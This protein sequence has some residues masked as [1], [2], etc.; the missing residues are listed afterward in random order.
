M[1][2]E[3]RLNVRLALSSQGMR[4]ISHEEYE[5]PIPD[6]DYEIDQIWHDYLVTIGAERQWIYGTG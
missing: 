1:N 4:I 6:L 2:L 3:N 5:T